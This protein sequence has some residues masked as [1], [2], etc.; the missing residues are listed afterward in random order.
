[1]P[2]NVFANKTCNKEIAMV[3]AVAKSQCQVLS[4]VR[5]GLFRQFR[6][7]LLNQERVRQPLIHKDVVEVSMGQSAAEQGAGIMLVPFCS[8][9]PQI[10]GECLISPRTVRG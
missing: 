9:A 5:C 2:R 6:P 4:G 1:M 8:V 10:G 7:Q 3:V